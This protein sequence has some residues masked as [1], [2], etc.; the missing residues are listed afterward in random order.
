[1][2]RAQSISINPER[3]RM[4]KTVRQM[5]W[6]ELAN[7]VKMPQSS[8]Q[9]CVCRGRLSASRLADLAKALNVDPKWLTGQS[10]S[11]VMS[12]A[13]HCKYCRFCKPV[14]ELVGERH[15]CIKHHIYR[16][17]PEK[18]WCGWAI[19]KGLVKDD[20]SADDTV[21]GRG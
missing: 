17:D 7:A 11:P 3:V 18:D 10:D 8:F 4:A 12:G 6:A 19:G 16:V 13:L 9:T 5:E 14:R 21:C 20:D 15:I 1:M 2:S